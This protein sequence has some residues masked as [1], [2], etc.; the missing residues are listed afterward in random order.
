MA[1]LNNERSRLV[2]L[3]AG[4]PGDSRITIRETDDGL[5]I[6]NPSH[7]QMPL[8]LFLLLW[9][10]GWA[11]GEFFALSQIFSG[12]GPFGVDLFLLFW[13][14]FWTLGGALA[15]WFV[16]WQLF[17]VEQLFITSG[18]V[19]REAG[20]W[21]LRRR[22]VYPLGSV[23]EFELAAVP[24]RQNS[25]NHAITF[26]ADGKSRGFGIG[27]SPDEAEAALDAI[28]KFIARE[29]GA[30]EAGDEPAKG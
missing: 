28:R 10:G 11:F 30:A 7:R 6:H 20:L 16:L 1:E 12:G 9:L 2:S 5:G 29:T 22:R 14:T 8:I 18:A 3:I 26:K 21:R 15:W 19:V 24:V 13:V 23:S 4:K 27:M 25:F 17:G